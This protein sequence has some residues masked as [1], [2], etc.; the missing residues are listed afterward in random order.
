MPPGWRGW[1]KP[2]ACRPLV[3]CWPI[4]PGNTA[5]SRTASSERFP[6][7]PDQLTGRSAQIDPDRHRGGGDDRGVAA[8]VVGDI[9]TAL[10]GS[11][12]DL[13]MRQRGFDRRD[14]DPVR[15]LHPDRHL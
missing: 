12:G 3:V 13:A 4:S 15:L 9:E 11:H 14:I 5:G 6:R 2:N 8:V 10:D 1:L 7:P